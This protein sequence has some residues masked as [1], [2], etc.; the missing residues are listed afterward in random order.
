MNK[1]Y[2]NYLCDHS[3][4]VKINVVQKRKT[5]GPS[6]WLLS[7]IWPT[8]KKVWP[9]PCSTI[10]L[11]SFLLVCKDVTKTIPTDLILVVDRSDSIANFDFDTLRSVLA[12]FLEGG[13]ELTNTTR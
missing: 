2:V 1:Y 10:M 3:F 9:P 6:E 8:N 4:H 13:L 5:F 11:V 12:N 7:E